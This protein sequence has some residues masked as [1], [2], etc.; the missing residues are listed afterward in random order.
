MFTMATGKDG[1]TRKQL[2]TTLQPASGHQNTGTLCRGLCAGGGG[3][4]G[5]TTLC[6]GT[7]QPPLSP[8]QIVS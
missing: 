5:H 4:G 3:G 8:L 2:E 7:L 6:G 1:R